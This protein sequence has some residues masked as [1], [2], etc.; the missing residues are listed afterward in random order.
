MKRKINA[1]LILLLTVTLAGCPLMPQPKSFDQ[2]LAYAY[3][4]HTALMVSA[5][6]ALELGTLSLDDAQQ[7]L[8]IADEARG[9]LDL[10]KMTYLSGDVKTAEGQLN[11]ALSLLSELQS[12][13]NSKV[14]K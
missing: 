1:F 7:V 11:M 3:G 13:V 14:K 4:T 8:K 10:S 6:N 5:K 9:I 12:Y 2:S